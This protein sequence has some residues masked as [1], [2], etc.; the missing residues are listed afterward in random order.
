MPRYSLTISRTPGLVESHGLNRDKL[1][2][3]RIISFLLSALL[4]LL[5]EMGVTARSILPCAKRS[6]MAVGAD[7]AT[8]S[9]GIKAKYDGRCQLSLRTAFQSHAPLG[10]EGHS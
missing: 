9:L 1:G 6:S 4:G 3:S 10:L 7:E 8:W 5:W 2:R